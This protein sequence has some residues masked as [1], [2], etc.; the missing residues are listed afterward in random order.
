MK[1]L[2]R[3]QVNKMLQ[4]PQNTS[5]NAEKFKLHPTRNG[6]HRKNSMKKIK[7]HSKQKLMFVKPFKS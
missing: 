2:C 4:K 5:A 6:G 3:L 7:I 1:K